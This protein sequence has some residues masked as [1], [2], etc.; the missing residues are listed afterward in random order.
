SAIKEKHYLP[1]PKVLDVGDV[2]TGFKEADL[3]FE[4]N[5]EL[6]YVVVFYYDT[7]PL[8]IYMNSESTM[9]CKIAAYCIAQQN[10]V[11]NMCYWILYMTRVLSTPSLRFEEIF[12]HYC[13]RDDYG[14]TRAFLHGAPILYCCT[15]RRGRGDRYHNIK[16]MPQCCT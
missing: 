13:R 11:T 14:I 15:N 9:Q 5:F 12:Y 6:K 7:C 1:N 2:E 3:V 8:I 10:I 16:T 4:G